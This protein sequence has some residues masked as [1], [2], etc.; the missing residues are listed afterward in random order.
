MADNIND[1]VLRL[2][3]ELTDDQ[4]AKIER[5]LQKTMLICL[6]DL[7]LLEDRK[8]EGIDLALGGPGIG[9]TVGMMIM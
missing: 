7:D 3:I 4:R 1:F 9:N 5:E 6:A 2:N 8:I